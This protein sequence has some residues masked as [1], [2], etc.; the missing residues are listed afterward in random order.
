[1]ARNDDETRIDSS[2]DETRIERVEVT[3]ST[4]SPLPGDLPP[5]SPEREQGVVRETETV[6]QRADGAIETERYRT[7]DRRRASRDQVGIW[8]AVFAALLLAG[9][10]AWW[11]LTREDSRDVPAVEGLAVED[12]VARL[13]D[14][15]FDSDTVT[16]ESDEPEGQVVEQDP[17]AGTEADSG[18]TVRITVSSGPGTTEVPNAVGLGEAEARDRLVAA[19][20][21]VDSQDVFAEKEPGSVVSQEPAAGSDAEPDSTVTLKVSRGTGLVDVPSVVGLTRA[22]A[23]AELSGAKL[24]ANV[25]E[26]PSDDVEG[27]VV[28]QNPVGG[29]LRQGSAVR[30]N[31]SSGR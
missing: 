18:S 28:A 24:E 29:K 19:G 15:G 25:V 14:D 3:D 26:V 12:A 10:G 31:V 27:T 16:S 5:G 17:A 1:M 4:I 23:E 13:E 22:E 30:L 21:Q 20:F 7:E 9:A 6:R 8:L 11:L 2:D